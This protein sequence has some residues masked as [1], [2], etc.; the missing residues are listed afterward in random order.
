LAANV[1]PRDGSHQPQGGERLSFR[2]DLQGLSESACDNCAL[3]A[4]LI[5]GKCQGIYRPIQHRGRPLSALHP[6]ATASR[7]DA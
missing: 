3:Q 2:A 1:G 6:I 4:R 5:D 7:F